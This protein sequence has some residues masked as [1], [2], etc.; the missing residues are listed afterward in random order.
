MKPVLIGHHIKWEPNTK[1]MSSS[2]C[3]K[4][5]FPNFIKT[6]LC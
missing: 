2:V 4:H 6:N 5:Y 1:Q 3:F